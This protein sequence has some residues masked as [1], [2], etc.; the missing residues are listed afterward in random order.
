MKLIGIG[1]V[2]MKVAVMGGH[3]CNLFLCRSLVVLRILVRATIH[4]SYKIFMRYEN[5]ATH[6]CACKQTK[7]IA[8]I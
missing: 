8:K 1:G 4:L 7:K 6:N 3:G 5:E 2:E